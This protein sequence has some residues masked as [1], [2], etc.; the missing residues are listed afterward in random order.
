MMAARKP[1]TRIQKLSRSRIVAAATEVFA[2]HGFRGATLD[3]IAEQAGMS[4]TNIL[5]YFA[6]K[7]VVYRATIEATLDDWLGS[8]EAL[9]PDGDP[10]TELR[11]YLQEKIRFSQE[12]PAASRLFASEV[13]QGAEHCR[14]ILSDRVDALM[15]SAGAA[16]RGWV[17]RG[18]VVDVDPYNLL[19]VL[20]AATQTFADFAA[21]IEAVTGKTLA[22]DDYFRQVSHDLE[23]ILLAGILTGPDF[24]QQSSKKPRQ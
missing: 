23:T 22:D 17:K 16:I 10:A 1:L 3:D 20:F 18:L 14:D 2:R 9:D 5:Y 11:R 19:F 13:L 7:D 21:Q 15:K 24:S 6:S 8:L 12:N 4:K